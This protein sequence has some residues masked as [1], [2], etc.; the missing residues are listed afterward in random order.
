MAAARHCILQLTSKGEALMDKEILQGKRR[1]LKG[2]IKEQ[3]GKLTDDDLDRIEGQAERLVGLLQQRYGYAKEKAWQ[4]YRR[5][6][7]QWIRKG[8]GLD[9]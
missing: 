1:E 5:V 7:E 4:E 2:F 6:M 3:W 8:G 9:T